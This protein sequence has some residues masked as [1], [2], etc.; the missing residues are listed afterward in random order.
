M[1]DGVCVSR[2]LRFSERTRQNGAARMN[3]TA[4]I[5]AMGSLC[6]VRGLSLPC[7]AHIRTGSGICENQRSK[8]VTVASFMTPLE[9]YDE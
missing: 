9:I 4:S 3:V 1:V 5:F 8:Q 2:P 6:G 7:R